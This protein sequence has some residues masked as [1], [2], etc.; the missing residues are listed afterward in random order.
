MR[1]VTPKSRNGHL[2]REKGEAQRAKGTKMAPKQNM[3]TQS[4]PCLQ[5]AGCGRHA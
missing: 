3:A 5:Q 2:N 1:D 4:L